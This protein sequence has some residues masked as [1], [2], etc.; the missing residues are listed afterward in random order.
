MD[1]DEKDTKGKGKR[2]GR[3]SEGLNGK[4]KKGKKGRKGLGIR[5]GRKKDVETREH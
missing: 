4:N 2:M 3:E 1:V 5:N